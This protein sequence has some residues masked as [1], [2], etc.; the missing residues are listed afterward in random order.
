MIRRHYDPVSLMETMGPYENEL[1]GFCPEE[2]L[3]FD[4][5]VCLTDGNG[6][7]TLFERVAPNAVYG[8]YFLLARGK[9]A[10]ELCKEFLSHV[11]AGPYGI[12]YIY[13][14]TPLNKKGALWMN[15]QLGFKPESI[16]ETSVGPC[17]FVSLA[18]E[19][20]NS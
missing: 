11:F 20:W 5:N 14:L 10:L 13:G 2:W 1:K 15:R 7:F 6:N 3:L 4:E 17:Q 9:L 16:A 8:H 19:D 12:D 18:K